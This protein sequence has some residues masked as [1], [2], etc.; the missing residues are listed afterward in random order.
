ME[1]KSIDTV[2]SRWWYRA[3]F[4]IENI[5]KSSTENVFETRLVNGT[6]IKMQLEK[7]NQR[8]KRTF[9]RCIRLVQEQVFA[10]S[11]KVLVQEQG[12]AQY[13]C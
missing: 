5:G 12:F 13:N 7:S 3:R 9:D 6:K 10:Q 2:K 1:R 8:E 4:F 11:W